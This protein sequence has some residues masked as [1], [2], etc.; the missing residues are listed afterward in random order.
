[1]H[2]PKN[3]RR[4]TGEAKDVARTSSG[5]WIRQQEYEDGWLYEISIPVAYG[6]HLTWMET[7]RIMFGGSLINTFTEDSRHFITVWIN[8]AAHNRLYPY[9]PLEYRFFDDRDMAANRAFTESWLERTAPPAPQG[10]GLR[11]AG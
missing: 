4:P 8:R 5:A 3:P 2:G 7:S 1:M 6:R 9:G 11:I 10:P